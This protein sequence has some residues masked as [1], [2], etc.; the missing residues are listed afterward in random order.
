M[1]GRW[2]TQSPAS[3]SVST[4]PYMKRA[5]PFVMKTM[6]NSASCRCQPVPFSGAMLAFTSCAITR[7][8]VACSTPRSRYRKKSRSPSL[9]HGVSAGLDVRELHASWCPAWG[10]LRAALG[11][12][13]GMH[14]LFHEIGAAPCG[15]RAVSHRS[16]G[17]FVVAER[18]ARAEQVAV[19]PDV[20]DAADRRPV[21]LRAQRGERIGRLLAR[22]RRA[23]TRP[24]AARPRCAARAFSGLSS[25]GQA[26]ASTCAISARIA[27]IASQKRSSSSSDS[28]SVGST[29]SVPATGKLSVGA[30]KP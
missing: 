19:A 14:N 13:R 9:R 28:L 24:R 30:W 10:D 18:R 20:V 1:P 22:V 11:A 27:I 26:P 15:E 8:A 6:W 7:P 17:A 29:I 4:S 16:S 3:T 23:A 12:A 5:Q 2:C 21:L 25:R